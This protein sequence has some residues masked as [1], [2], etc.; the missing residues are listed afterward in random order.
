[1]KKLPSYEQCSCPSDCYM[2]D[3]EEDPNKP[4]WGEVRAID[5]IDWGDD[6]SWVHACEGHASVYDGDVYEENTKK[7]DK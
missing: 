2:L 6:W 7:E 5:E 4:C 1:M 3:I